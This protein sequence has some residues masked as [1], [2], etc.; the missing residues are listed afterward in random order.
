MPKTESTGRTNAGTFLFGASLIGNLVLIV[1]VVLLG[2]ALMS[3]IETINLTDYQRATIENTA[4]ANCTKDVKYINKIHAK[5]ID[6]LEDSLE[7]AIDRNKGCWETLS[8]C[9][10]IEK[11]YASLVTDTNSVLSSFLLDL[12]LQM[13]NHFKD[14]NSVFNDYN[15]S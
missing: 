1:A 3:N 13:G 2:V 14:I 11:D 10:S 9:T 12:N 7:D 15:C 6:K 5:E 8:E 4:Q